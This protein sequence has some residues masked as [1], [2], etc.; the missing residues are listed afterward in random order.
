MG[1][2]SE[3]MSCRP[4]RGLWAGRHRYLPTY[5][6]ELGFSG[7]DG[8][9]CPVLGKHSIQLPDQGGTPG[10]H[11]CRAMLVRAV[12][13]AMDGGL[14]DYVFA[15]QDRT[16][17]HA[18][19]KTKMQRNVTDDFS[20]DIHLPDSFYF[21]ICVFQAGTFGLKTQEA[22]ELHE[23]CGQSSRPQLARAQKVARW[24]QGLLCAGSPG[25]Q[26]SEFGFIMLSMSQL[27]P[28]T[29]HTVD[30]RQRQHLLRSPGPRL[31]AVPLQS[32]I[33]VAFRPAHRLLHSL[34]R[35]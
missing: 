28:A 6:R 33:R 13:S 31:P 24:I 14:K 23:C 25:C 3:R 34:F 32:I 18:E 16:T 10:L 2:V 35:P 4:I 27:P 19:T 22:A 1:A 29:H 26:D 8:C 12:L 20:H 5:S 11:R 17:C 30:P 21:D 15:P 7:V 9:R